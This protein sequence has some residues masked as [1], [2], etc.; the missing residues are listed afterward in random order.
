MFIARLKLK[1]FKSFGG[2][3]DLPLS[4]GFT[5]IVGPNGSGKSNILDGLRWGLG[6]S[7]GSRLRITKQSDLL[8]QGTAL[9]KPAK[10]A[11]VVLEFADGDLRTTIKRKFSDET[12]AVTY[13]DGVKCRVQ[14]LQDVKHRWHLGG[15]RFA[16]IGQG[17]VTD[18]ISQ[19]PMDRRT[20]LEELFGINVYRRK[21]DEALSKISS[22]E[23]ELA[24]LYS[25]MAELESRRRQIAPMVEVALRAITLERDLDDTRSRWYHLKRKAGEEAVMDLKRKVDSTRKEV[26]YRLSWKIIWEQSLSRVKDGARS[27]ELRRIEARRAL[28]EVEKDLEGLTRQAFELETSLRLEEERLAFTEASVSSLQSNIDGLDE[29]LKELAEEHD[30][31]ST[32]VQEIGVEIEDLENRHRTLLEAIRSKEEERLGCLQ[33]QGDIQSAIERGRA[34]Q[35]ALLSGEEERLSLIKKLEKDVCVL[36]ADIARSIAEERDLSES[37]D[38]AELE[39]RDA[40]DRCKSI[41]TKIQPLRKDIY[42]KEAELDGLYSSASG[43]SYPKPVNHLLAASDLGRMA[44]R[45]TPVVEAFQCPGN[46][47]VAIEAALGGRQFWLLAQSLS[48]AQEGI[49]E[50]K[51]TKSGRVTYLTLDRVRPR[52]PKDGVVLPQNGVV[53]WAMDL[54]SVQ[55]IWRPAMEHLIGDLLIV[56]S[57]PVGSSMVSGGYTMPIVTLDGEVFSPSGTVSGGASNRAG[58]IIQARSRQKELE[59]GLRGLKRNLLSL[60]DALK[61]SEENESELA[62]TVQS[63]SSKLHVVQKERLRGDKA[64]SDMERDMG[65]LL[66]ENRAVE[67]RGKKLKEDLALYEKKLLEEEQRLADMAVPEDNDIRD[68]LSRLKPQLLL[69]EERAKASWERLKAAEEESDGKRQELSASIKA[70]L[71]LKDRKDRQSLALVDIKDK[72]VVMEENRSN[73]LSV[74]GETE[75]GN[76]RINRALDRCSTRFS[77]ACDRLDEGEKTLSWM[78]QKLERERMRLEDL[79]SSWDHKYPYPGAALDYPRSLED[80]ERRLKRLEASLAE[81]G[82]FDRGAVSENRSLEDRIG[83]YSDQTKDVSAGVDELRSLVEDTDRQAG[84]IFGEALD[85]IDKRFNGLFQRLFGGGESHLRLQD[86]GGLWDS[87]VEIIAR[88]PGKVSAYLAQLSGGE[89][90]LTALSLLFASMEVAQVP[91]AVLDEVDAALDEVNLSRFAGIVSDY[92]SSLQIIAM[93]HRRQTMERADVMYGV[94]MSEPGLSQVVGVKLEDWR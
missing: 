86:E 42:R 67:D 72:I 77:M 8:F 85:R 49:E 30:G 45:P 61:K 18:A 83:Y 2:G 93:T 81:I 20:H 64:L 25:L 28:A 60:E 24:R 79:S 1:N 75:Q 62:G 56:E 26:E 21:R 32:K 74:L 6:D 19:R 33:R 35:K 39:R 87:G 63:L 22:A 78:E 65:V 14:D 92:S 51:R 11:E 9:Q 17:D 53:G 10:S 47:A 55:A 90:T 57:Y 94:T 48:D 89:Q 3:H 70:L 36:K 58:G 71:A 44:F 5:A 80:E 7:N 68:S 38:R 73:S 52:K 69:W 40:E 84:S 43:E 66:A 50:L 29:R 34:A 76:A 12:G 27:V 91:L 23:Q 31:A 41:A 13:V 54:L 37:V 59:E 82:D 88:P 16:F 46:L 4:P 15:D